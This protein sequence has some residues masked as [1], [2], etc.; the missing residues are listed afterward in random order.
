[1]TPLSTHEAWRH[2]LRAARWQPIVAAAGLA[3]AFAH[4]GRTPP[5]VR[6]VLVAATLAIGSSFVIDD[7]AAAT[8]A[9]SP[10]A[11]ST[12]RAMRV[13]LAAGLTA[14]MWLPLLPVLSRSTHGWL[15]IW[16]ATLE[17]ATLLA[18][19]LAIATFACGP[20]GEV[21]GGAIAPPTLL[22]LLA[23][24]AML[25]RSLALFPIGGHEVR[26]VLVLSLAAAT[27]AWASR[28]PALRR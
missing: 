3:G 5:E 25:P 11:L 12:R 24:A 26:W 9:S 6:L 28:D 19:V 1:V 8:L 14:A 23:V 16:P 22:A 17:L 7:A 10:T 13:L 21:P 2:L 27:V 20:S 15:R 18:I 4:F